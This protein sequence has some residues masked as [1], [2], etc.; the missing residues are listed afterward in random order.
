M[1]AQDIFGLDFNPAELDRMGREGLGSD[2]ED[3]LEDED[4]E[5]CLSLSLCLVCLVV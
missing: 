2:E 4:E 1:E 3:E 5:V